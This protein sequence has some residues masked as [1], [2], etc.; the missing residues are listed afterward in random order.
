MAYV[1]DQIKQNGP[2]MSKDLKK[3]PFIKEEAWA[4]P[5][6]KQALMHL[7]M[8][9][10]IMIAGRR[11]FQK[12]YDIPERIL[13]PSVNNDL[14][15]RNEY[16]EYVIRRD[17]AAHGLIQNKHVGHLLKI[18]IKEKQTILDRMVKSDELETVKIKGL[19]SLTYYAFSE[20]IK[21]YSPSTKKKNFYILS[22]FD[23]LV[24]LRKR[25][26]T[27]FD[28]S[29]T[30]ECYVPA[31][32][33][34]I[35]Y[36][37]LPLLYGKDFV[38]QIDLKADRKNKTLLIRNLVWEPGLKNPEK[39]YPQLIQKLKDFALFN[40]CSSIKAEIDDPILLTFSLPA[41]IEKIKPNH[42]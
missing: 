27:L 14:P 33:R 25:V 37:S 6:V 32:K 1:L 12:I 16:I 42:K 31:A 20:R 9:G 22:P 26:A 40:N 38:G 41:D 24:I 29:Y 11:G 7:F 3:G 17:I 30:L 8:E 18:S 2:L 13:P 39:I 34:K 10:K 36:F 15:S 23:N 5:P 21:Q 28:F 35:G 4:I 19:E